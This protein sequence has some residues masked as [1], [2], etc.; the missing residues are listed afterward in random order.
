[1]PS[2]QESML[3]TSRVCTSSCTGAFAGEMSLAVVAKTINDSR[4]MAR[5]V[6]VRC[7][8]SFV[9]LLAISQLIEA[10]SIPR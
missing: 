6:Q 3:I 8:K 5:P 4:H 9:F 10:I 7:T 1:M 2:Y